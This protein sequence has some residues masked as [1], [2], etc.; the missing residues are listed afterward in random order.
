MSEFKKITKCRVCGTE[1]TPYFDFGAMELANKLFSTREEALN[2]KRYP[3]EL[4]RCPQ[5]LNSQLSVVVDPKILYADY[6]YRSSISGPLVRHFHDLAEKVSSSIDPGDIAVDIGGNDGAF[7][8][9]LSKMC[10]E[11]QPFIIDPSAGALMDAPH[12]IGRICTFWG[13]ETADEFVRTHG[14]AKLITAMNV[15]A[16]VDDVNGFFEGVHIALADDGIFI[17]EAS[18][19]AGLLTGCE[20]DSV[21]HEHLSYFSVKALQTLAEAHGLFLTFVDS[22]DIH[23]GCLRAVFQRPAIG[24]SCMVGITDDILEEESTYAKFRSTVLDKMISINSD[25]KS[26]EGLTIGVTASAKASVILN[27]I[28]GSPI[29]YIVEDSRPK[30]GKFMGG[31]GIEI[32]AATKESVERADTAIILSRNLVDVLTARLKELNFKG[33]I[34][35]V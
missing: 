2:A 31:T 20:F 11:I 21:Y 34:I 14:K 3:L 18:S 19:A 28:G 7:L 9:E 24:R 32:V 35:T 10:P 33:R 4:C 29:R 27:L 15:A 8:R 26:S 12:T 16:H 5:C 30:I 1:T 22:I 17:L 23:F 25:I 6:P 13:S